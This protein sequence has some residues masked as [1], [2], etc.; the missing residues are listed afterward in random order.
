MDAL[1]SLESNQ[2]ARSPRASLTLLSCSANFPRAS[3]TRH[4][5]AKHEQILY[6]FIN[7]QLFENWK[8]IVLKSNR[9]SEMGQQTPRS[10]KVLAH[11]AH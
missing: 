2:K 1:E 11:P 4:S 9:W 5:H 3:I 6:L 8:G 7:M 10:N